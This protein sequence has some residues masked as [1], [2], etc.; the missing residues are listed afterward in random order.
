MSYF[1][2]YPGPCEHPQNSLFR[3]KAAL[4]R[5]ELAVRVLLGEPQSLPGQV[6][7]WLESEQNRLAIQHRSLAAKLIGEEEPPLR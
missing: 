7:A 4:D 6:K 3:E 5:R 1:E 2:N